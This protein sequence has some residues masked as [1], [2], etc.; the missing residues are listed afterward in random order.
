MLQLV[1]LVR[2][3]P[4]AKINETVVA[5]RAA[6]IGDVLQSLGKDSSPFRTFQGTLRDLASI[7]NSS[8]TV[9]AGATAKAI[10]IPIRHLEREV[11]SF[12]RNALAAP[13]SIAR[14]EKLDGIGV[15][16]IFS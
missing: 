4:S 12:V 5:V 1:S 3:L 11:Q 14:S 16:I 6:I 2:I 7:S 9:F 10:H 15:E 8:N 13:A